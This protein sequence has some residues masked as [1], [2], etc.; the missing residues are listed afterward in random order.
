VEHVD[1]GV[2]DFAIG[3]KEL[4]SEHHM[5]IE[6][7]AALAKAVRSDGARAEIDDVADRLVEFS[8]VHFASE[9][10]LMRLYG[11]EHMAA[12]SLDHERALGD[13]AAVKRALKDSD[14]DALAAVLQ[15]LTRLITGHIRA[16]DRAFAEY[17][18][19]LRGAADGVAGR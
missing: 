17:L 1:H 3:H 12:H 8:K 15:R 13:M 14:P 7:L 4:D 16:S 11:Y 6:L 9:E 5:Q 10:L 2:D 19:S 18:R